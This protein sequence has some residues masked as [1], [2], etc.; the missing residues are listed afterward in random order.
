MS[1]NQRVLLVEFYDYIF[2]T[3]TDEVNN[4]PVPMIS[5]KDK[6]DTYYD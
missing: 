6:C 1:L 2:K 4:V 5:I 3:S